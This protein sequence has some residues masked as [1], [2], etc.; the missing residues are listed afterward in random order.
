MSLDP[1]YTARS[2]A[3]A[4]S[5]R[6]AAIQQRAQA[7]VDREAARLYDAETND[8]AARAMEGARHDAWRDYGRGD[9]YDD[10]DC[11]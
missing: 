1:R 5:K 7:E 6:I 10:V 8:R 4:N 3:I 9:D 11:D 2:A